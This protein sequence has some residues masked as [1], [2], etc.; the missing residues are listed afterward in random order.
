M[1]CDKG[2]SWFVTG[3]DLN[4][5]DKSEDTNGNRTESTFLQ[6]LLFFLILLV[7]KYIVGYDISVVWVTMLTLAYGISEYGI[8][9]MKDRR[10]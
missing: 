2:Y 3:P 1:S 9:R 7:I 4:Y 5:E 6:A 8:L 10:K